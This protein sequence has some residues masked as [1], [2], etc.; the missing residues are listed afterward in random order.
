MEI[1]GLPLGRVDKYTVFIKN[2][3][4][5]PHFGKQYRR[6]NVI[7]GPKPTIYDEKRRPLGQI[8]WLGDIVRLAGGN[9]TQLSIKGGVISVSIQ[10]R[11]NLDFD[12]MEHCLPAYE[13]RYGN[14]AAKSEKDRSVG[15]R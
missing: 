6:N 7:P 9:F 2:S 12:F 8:F 1:D 13:F 3:I 5:F 11:C 10:W 15:G 14:R 4:A